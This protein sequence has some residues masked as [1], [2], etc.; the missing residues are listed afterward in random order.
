KTPVNMLDRSYYNRKGQSIAATIF[1]I[2]ERR[3]ANTK[4]V[5]E[6][7]TRDLAAFSYEL[8]IG[9]DT[10]QMR[11]WEVELTD[12][13]TPSG[14]A[15]QQ[16]LGKFAGFAWCGGRIGREVVHLIR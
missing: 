4:Q 13:C 9:L 8:Y 10:D 12:L 15:L 6:V 14:V 2:R 11:I 5:R 16:Q 1:P 3:N 7:F